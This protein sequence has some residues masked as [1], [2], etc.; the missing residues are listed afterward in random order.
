MKGELW[1]VD[2][3]FLLH[4]KD[5]VP[6]WYGGNLPSNVLE[7]LKNTGRFQAGE[8]VL[9]AEFK[10]SDKITLLIRFAG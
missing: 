3:A 5:M 10:G 6:G 8:T 7:G 4:M 2:A 9:T 1:E